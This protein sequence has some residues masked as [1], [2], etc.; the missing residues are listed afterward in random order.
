MLWLERGSEEESDRRYIEKYGEEKCAE[1]FLKY[2]KITGRDWVDSYL[3]MGRG[4]NS[5]SL[6]E[7]HKRVVLKS[8]E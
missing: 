4:N 2:E 5:Y 7:F 1:D 8:I 3:E 6:E